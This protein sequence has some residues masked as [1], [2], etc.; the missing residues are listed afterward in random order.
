MAASTRMTTDVSQI[1]DVIAITALGRKNDHSAQPQCLTFN[2]LTVHENNRGKD[3][4]RK[5]RL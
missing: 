5:V 1:M 3:K 2:K 4:Q